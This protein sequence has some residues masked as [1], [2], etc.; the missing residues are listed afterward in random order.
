MKDENKTK[1]QLMNEL[2]ELRHRITELEA[3]ETERKRAEEELK[4]E[5]GRAEEYLNI[6]GVMLAALD[7]DGN[8]TLINRKGSGILGY[9]EGELIGRNWFDILVPQRV[10]GEIRGVFR[11]LMAGDIEPVEYYENPLLTKDGEERL[12]L[13]HNTVLRDPNG[14]IVG[15][16]TSGE[17]ITER[18]KAEEALRESEECY[19]TLY[20]S[21]RDGIA[22]TNLKGTVTECNQAY[23][24][25]LGY[26]REELKKIRYQDITPSKWHAFN[27]KIFQEVMERGYSDVFEKEYIRKDGRVFPVSL[28]T[29]RIDDADGKPIGLGSTVRDITEWKRAE[30]ALRESEERYHS[31]FEDSR[32]AVYTTAQEGKLLNANPGQ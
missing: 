27:E 23:A 8:I 1:E 19:R 32:D 5:R 31:L 21:S 16:L 28:H 3:S 13:F 7:A 12:I 29:W 26:S 17:D 9:N 30:E 6:V 18:K 14:Q 11:K 4:R 22:T 10:R 24:K 2:E 20:E 25:M 15:A